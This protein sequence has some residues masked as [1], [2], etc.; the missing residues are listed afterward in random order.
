M[1]KLTE[2]E[3]EYMLH[4]GF[5]FKAAKQYEQIPD[6][7]PVITREYQR[8][9]ARMLEDPFLYAAKQ[10]RTVVQHIKRYALVAVL[11]LAILAGTI[12]AIPQARTIAIDLIKQWFDDGSVSLYFKGSRSDFV[13]PEYEISYIPEGYVLVFED[14]IEGEMQVLSYE[15]SARQRLSIDIFMSGEQFSANIN[16]EHSTMS[17]IKLGNG[18]EAQLFEGES[19]EWSSNLVWTSDNGRIF[20]LINGHLP[21][22]ELIKIADGIIPK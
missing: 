22:K 9:F 15:D 14:S 16:T 8:K 7:K 13:V 2:Q 4:D 1:T 5:I 20:Y 17:Y 11:V 18:I 3:L 19:E 6:T 10:E 12:L 21:P